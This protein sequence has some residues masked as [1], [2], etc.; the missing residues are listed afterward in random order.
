MTDVMVYD[1]KWAERITKRIRKAG[2]DFGAL[3]LEAHDGKAWRLRGFKSWAAYVDAEFE[4]TRQHSYKLIGQEQANRR[5]AASGSATR[6]TVT[7]AAEVSHDATVSE[8]EQTVYERR[9]VPVPKPAG[10]RR[11]GFTAPD[12][13]VRV[14]VQRY[15]GWYEQMDPDYP[16]EASFVRVLSQLRDV[17]DSMLVVADEASR[18]PVRIDEWSA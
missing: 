18:K 4:F 6:L 10:K 1:A 15:Q 7:E 16:V 2:E 14:D 9:S 3:L 13:T 12:E 5:L 8:I 17:I 11:R